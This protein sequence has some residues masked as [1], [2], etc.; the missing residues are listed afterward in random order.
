MVYQKIKSDLRAQWKTVSHLFGEQLPIE[1]AKVRFLAAVPFLIGALLSAVVAAFFAQAFHQVEA[2]FFTM[3]KTLGLWTLVLTPSCFVLSCAA[4]EWF[5]PQAGGSGIPQL[6]ASVELAM[7]DS[8]QAALDRLLGWRILVVKI[9]SSLMALAGGGAIGREGPTLQVSGVIFHWVGRL[10][11]RGQHFA[12]HSTLIIAGG[13]AGLA[14]AFNTPMGGVTYAMEELSKSH[15][16][17]FRTGLLQAV[18]AAGL[19]AQWIMGP[20]LYL[21][22]PKVVRLDGSGFGHIVIIA[23][24][25]GLVAALF[26]LFLKQIFSRRLRLKTLKAKLILAGV[27]GFGVAALGLLLG[28]QVWGSGRELLASLLFK[29][30]VVGAKEVVGRFG[31]TLATY[32]SG[33]AGGVFAPTLALGA[34]TASFVEALLQSELGTVGILAGMTA[35]LS[36]LTLS[37]LTAFVLI[38][39]MTDRHSAIFPLMIS[40]LIGQGV[41]RFVSQE[42]FYEYAASWILRGMSQPS[43]ES[44]EYS[45]GEDHPRQAEKAQQTARRN[46]FSESDSE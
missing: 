46:E 3:S 20:Y 28:E 14:S 42:S 22:Y 41:A 35:A 26:A 18:I 34:A 38:L 9:L 11:G 12:N 15:F 6:M 31:A 36:A 10:F 2:F 17:S 16:A 43:R 13:A 21:G 39:E 24:S 40:A 45:G 29:G 1:E 8:K 7:R 27:M 5:A 30:E 23:V 37:P 4:V 25:A 32:A 19:T 33:G 44:G